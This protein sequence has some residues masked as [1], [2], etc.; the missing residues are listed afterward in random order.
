MAEDGENHMVLRCDEA[1]GKHTSCLVTAG[2][3]IC[4][5]WGTAM[6]ENLEGG[7]TVPVNLLENGSEMLLHFTPFEIKTLRLIP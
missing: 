7:K 3:K 5:V 1:I 6:E 2:F 4:N